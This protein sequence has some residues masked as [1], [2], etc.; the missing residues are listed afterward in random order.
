MAQAEIIYRQRNMISRAFFKVPPSQQWMA[1]ID[2]NHKQDGCRVT[3]VF[4]NDQSAATARYP[5]PRDH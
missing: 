1:A 3:P 2:P 5:S 4:G